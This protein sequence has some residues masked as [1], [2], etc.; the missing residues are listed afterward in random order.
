MSPSTL[1]QAE[2]VQV[3]GVLLVLLLVL[4]GQTL[5]AVPLVPLVDARF[6]PLLAVKAQPL[7]T[8]ASVLGWLGAGATVGMNTWA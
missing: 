7:S 3:P 4:V 5:T 6:A 1:F 8:T 2:G